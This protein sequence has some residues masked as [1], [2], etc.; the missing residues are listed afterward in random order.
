MSD[1]DGK[2]TAGWWIAGLLGAMIIS[3][4]GTAL[5]MRT[6]PA[7]VQRVVE[8]TFTDLSGTKG[9]YILE[10]RPRIERLERDYANISAL[11][12]QIQADIAVI[13]QQLKT[14]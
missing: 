3:N 9:L 7:E 1:D 8:S 12:G 10:G 2:K 13:R 14:R 6:T 4:I 5:A 11:L